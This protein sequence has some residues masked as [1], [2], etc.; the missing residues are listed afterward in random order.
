MNAAQTVA[1]EEGT[2]SFVTAPEMLF[3]VQAIGTTVVFLY[4][5]WI[6]YRAYINYGDGD[7]K[8]KDMIIIWF[9]GLFIMMVLLY[10]LTK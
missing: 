2:G 9:R 1:F 7:I 6:F 5:A 4:V 10:L 3:T 8:S